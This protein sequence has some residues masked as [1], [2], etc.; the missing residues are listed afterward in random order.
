M[1]SIITRAATIATIALLGPV[2]LLGACSGDGE[3]VSS[4][5]AKGGANAADGQIVDGQGIDAGSTSGGDSGTA[6]TGTTDTGATDTGQT[7]T[8]GGADTG[9]GP[10]ACTTNEQCTA[11]E[12]CGLFYNG[13]KQLTGDDD[14]KGGKTLP[15]WANECVATDAKLAAQGAKCDPFSA[16]TDTSLPQC[17]N[18]SAC[19]QG[20]CTS[21]CADDKHCVSGSIC[22]TSEVPVAV[23][24]GPNPATALLRVGICVPMPGGGAGCARNGDCKAGEVCRPFTKDSP[25]AGKLGAYGRCVKADAA[26][27]TVG[28]D[29][30]AKGKGTGLGKL[31]DSAL[32][33]YTQGG[34]VAGICTAMCAAKA[35]CPATLTYGGT[36][37]KTACKSILTARNDASDATDDVFIPHCILVHEDSTT[38]DCAA[39]KKCA[40][41]EACM[42]FAIA[43]GPDQ[44]A[45]V[46]H[47]CVAQATKEIPADKLL[48]TGAICDPNKANPGCKGG[49]CLPG[50]S[51]SGYCSR[52]CNTD[53]D[54][55]GGTKCVE[56]VLVPRADKA[57][58]ATAM[59]CMK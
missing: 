55:G 59:L 10:K 40:G 22:T 37:F 11:A 16:D 9:S 42:A 49:Y 28:Q 30:G 13:V 8:G 7:D 35:D 53:T 34:K 5:N 20:M 18:S 51:A 15:G 25:M 12:H 4:T 54:C 58:A 33:L 3:G 44:A 38:K 31:C 24:S 46:E 6:D 29:C 50:N 36:P 57:K 43:T 52:T 2:A 1:Q 47:L 14:G 26:K 23:Q 32:C 56:R 27:H 45:K 19:Q 41:S 48:A 39:D 17:H 21:L